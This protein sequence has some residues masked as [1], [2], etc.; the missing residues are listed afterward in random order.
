MN[1]E[2]EYFEDNLNGTDWLG[3]V[4]DNLDPKF[5]GR[6]KI[7]VFGK[8]DDLEDETIPWAYPANNLTNGSA[9]GGGMYS[10]PKIGNIVA[11]KF[12]NGNIYH[13]E[14]TFR[15]RI[16]DELKAEIEEIEDDENK[17]IFQSLFYDTDEILKLFYSLDKGLII[18]LKETILNFLNED[19]DDED[20][21]QVT[22]FTQGAIDISSVGLYKVAT[23]LTYDI[24][25]LDAMTVHTDLTFN[26]SSVDTMNITT[27]STFDLT[28]ADVTTITAP[29]IYLGGSGASEPLIFGEVWKSL[30]EEI[31]DALVAHIHPGP[32]GPTG[33]SLPPDGVTFT[34]VKAKL[35]TA[36]SSQNF[37]L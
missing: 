7:K 8:F 35:A 21:V 34:T 20:N 26:L 37:T 18:Q 15:Q 2:Q 10:V 27:D 6:V 13:P 25:A 31:L 30:L 11:V 14:Y 29:E 23:E 24:T 28:A 33:P 12:A 32:T 3:E 9:T 22:L 4:I 19:P 5:T 16:S 17:P 1:K 36:L